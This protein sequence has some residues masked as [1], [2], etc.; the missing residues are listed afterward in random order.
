MVLDA[1]YS[2]LGDDPDLGELVEMFVDEMPDRVTA[3]IDSLQSGDLDDLCRAAHQLKGASGS[4]GFDQITPYAS[5]VENFAREGGTEEEI[6]NS[7][8]ALI[9]LCNRLR[10]GT[11]S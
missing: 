8:D 11:P 1:V 7:V 9:S 2:S 3:L 6:R 10:A 5:K 4:Y